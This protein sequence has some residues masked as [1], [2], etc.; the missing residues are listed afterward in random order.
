[1]KNVI[2]TGKCCTFARLSS[3]RIYVRILDI[4]FENVEKEYLKYA[5]NK[6][7]CNKLNINDLNDAYF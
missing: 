5:T 7:D 2:D 1:L 4:I 3:A 6:N